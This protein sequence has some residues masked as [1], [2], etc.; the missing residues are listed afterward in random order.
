MIMQLLLLLAIASSATCFTSNPIRTFKSIS[1]RPH[2]SILAVEISDSTSAPLAESTNGDDDDDE[3]EYEEFENL[4]ESDFYGSEWKVGTVMD[5]K[6]KIEETW[7]RLVVQDGEFIAVWGDGGK[8]KWNFD[9]ASQ[10]LS[11]TKDT[12]GGWLGKQL[13]AGNVDDFYYLS[14]TVRGW[15]PISPANVVGQWQAIRLGIEKD[16]A[17][18]APWFEEDEEEEEPEATE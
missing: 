12:F 5:N 3:W 17:G 16:E 13:W 8:G 14:G 1:I 9:T 10:F 2:S 15:S 6:G 7:C 18:V 4:A 11:M